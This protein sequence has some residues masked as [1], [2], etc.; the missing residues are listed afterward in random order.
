MRSAGT[1][2]GANPSVGTGDLDNQDHPHILSGV[3]ALIL[4]YCRHTPIEF[5]RSRISQLAAP[6]V[7]RRITTIRTRDKV[8]MR[9]DTQDFIQRTVYLTGEWD[10]G[11]ARALRNTVSAGDL[12]VDVG[13]NVGYFSLLAAKRGAHVIAFEPN[14]ECRADFANNVA[15][16]DFRE[17]EIRATGIADRR[18]ADELYVENEQNLGAGSLKTV[19]GR[20]FPIEI[21][22]LD[23][24]LEGL[25]P[26]LIKLDIEGAELMALRG[27]SQVLAR[28]HAVICEVS[29]FSLRELGGSKEELFATMARHG[30]RSEI[31]SPIRRSNH[32]MHDICFQYDVLF[33][34]P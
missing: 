30:F 26:A 22:T 5:A 9:V 23:S 29:E 1:A 8:K 11:V 27:A 25:S 16:N 7:G 19:T 28:T 17:V 4:A 6:W 32:S 21:D 3:A 10:D 2:K 24:Q 20:H 14:P 12:F 31:I 34:K 13:A 18:G 33:V 15:L